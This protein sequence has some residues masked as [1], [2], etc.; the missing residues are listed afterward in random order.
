MAVWAMLA[1]A[2]VVRTH[3]VA[4]TAEAARTVGAKAPVGAP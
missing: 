4:A 3:H 2:A 1:G